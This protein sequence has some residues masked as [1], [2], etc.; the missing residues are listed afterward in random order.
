M[1]PRLARFARIAPSCV[2]GIAGLVLSA[3]GMSPPAGAA[4]VA[5]FNGAFD[6][7]SGGEPKSWNA[8]IPI[9]EETVRVV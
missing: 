2:A 9:V 4:P 3:A 1:P 5:G 7:W 8:S 6:D